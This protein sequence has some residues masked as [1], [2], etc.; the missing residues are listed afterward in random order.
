M[1]HLT[2]MDVI[3]FQFLATTHGSFFLI[4]P[5]S[6]FKSL[7]HSSY[8]ALHC[9]IGKP[10]T[11]E[12][13]SVNKS[14]HP[15]VHPNTPSGSDYVSWCRSNIPHNCPSW[16]CCRVFRGCE[17]FGGRGIINPSS[18]CLYSFLCWERSNIILKSLAHC[19]EC[20]KLIG[21]I[22][23]QDEIFFFS[24]SAILRVF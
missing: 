2:V 21:N 24:N 11:V 1:S 19:N 6:Y 12:T 8:C 13:T 4:L 20:R 23:L 22:A 5:S 18:S 10:A 15:L 3:S 16:S 17:G 14:V 9:S 7:C